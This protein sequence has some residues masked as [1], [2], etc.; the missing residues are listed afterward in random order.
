MLERTSVV[1]NDKE[2]EVRIEVGMPAEDVRFLEKS[3]HTLINGLPKIV[4]QAI[5]YQNIDQQ[6][7][8]HQVTLKLDQTYI[9]NQL[10]QQHLVAFVANN[11]ILPRKAVYPM[12]Q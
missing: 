3:Y 7:L 5:M 9:R 2:I 12:S 11:A 8:Q 6:A 10:E 4:D 1:I